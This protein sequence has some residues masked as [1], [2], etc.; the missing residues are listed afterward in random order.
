MAREDLYR[1][2]GPKLMEAQSLVILDEINALRVEAG[3][4]ERAPSQLVTALEAKL[5]TIAD[6]PWMGEQ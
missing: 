6:Y 3:L 4:A 2:F 1:A 5:A